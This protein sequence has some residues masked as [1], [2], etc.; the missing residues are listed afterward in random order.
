MDSANS[1][2]LTGKAGLTC[3]KSEGLELLQP[4]MGYRFSVDVLLLCDFIRLKKRE[5]VLDLGAGC[6][7]IALILAKR[8]EDARITAIEVQRDMACLALENIRLNGMEGHIRL[9]EWDLNRIHEVVA[10]G[11]FDHVVSNPPYRSAGSGRLCTHPC[12]ALARHEILTDLSRL[13]KSA[14][15][16]LRPGG[17]IS[18]IYPASLTV[19]L[20]STMREVQLE[21]KRMQM[22][23]PRPGANARLIVVE[24][25]KD[26][27][28][29]MTVLPPRY[30]EPI[31]QPR[32][33]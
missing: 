10:P 24:G 17:R 16:A 25:C 4:Q 28:E 3:L 8:H 21:P 7:V 14:R 33:I 26:A 27:G 20:L 5:Q 9:I 15:Y 13:L 18:L 30:I 2:L 29:E 23:Y 1:D 12:D 31:A 32:T 6:G 19:K 22:I 11:E